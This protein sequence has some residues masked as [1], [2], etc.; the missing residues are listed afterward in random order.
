MS[1]AQVVDREEVQ[2]RNKVSGDNLPPSQNIR[3]TP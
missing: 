1:V 2:K 3:A